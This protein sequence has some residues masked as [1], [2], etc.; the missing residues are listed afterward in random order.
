M[1]TWAQLEGF[2]LAQPEVDGQ[3]APDRGIAALERAQAEGH[4]DP[5]WEPQQLLVLLFAIALSW[6]HGPDPDTATPTRTSSPPVAPR[7][8][9]RRHASSNV[10][11]V[12][13]ETAD[14]YFARVNWLTSM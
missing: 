9:R 3:R 7:W 11:D 12:P 4:V 10:P 8:S 13:I 2:P 6:A 14:R 5:T 1:I